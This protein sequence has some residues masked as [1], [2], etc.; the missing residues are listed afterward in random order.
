MHVSVVVPIHNE[1]ENIPRLYAELR[2]VLDAGERTW[3]L[4]FVDDGSTD[5]SDWELARVAALDTRVRIVEL[6]RNF[7]QT[8]ALR[9]GI[10]QAAG[11]VI[12]TLDGDLQN[13]PA[14][15][16]ALLAKIEEGYDLVHGWRKDRQDAFL[17]RTLPSRLAN[18]LISRAT[19]FAAH[20][21]GCSLK[22]I[23]RE[24]ARELDLHGEMHRFIPI[25]AHWRGA[26]SIEIE[27]HHR[28]RRFGRSKYG[29]SRIP[30]VLLDL[31][32]VKYFVRHLASPMKLFGTIGLACGLLGAAAA[33]A[34]VY[35]KLAHGLDMTG[36]PLLL[37]SVFSTLVG[38]QFVGLGMLGELGARTYYAIREGEPY[39]VRRVIQFDGPRNRELNQPAVAGRV[40]P[41]L[42]PGRR[43][44]A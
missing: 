18:R 15:I 41:V 43:N 28:P 25:L 22:A 31:I 1:V 7:G 9:A 20:D 26:R 11:E 13:D 24:V 33:G 39:A 21:L 30:G 32:T 3:E 36:N 6:R 17:T 23:R 14:D 2:D 4:I 38:V 44:A 16:P 42:H 19:G 27:T 8:A 12:V 34:T 37:L 40:I 35:M 29:L 5:G 10:D